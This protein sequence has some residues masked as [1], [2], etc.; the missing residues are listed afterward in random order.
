MVVCRGCLP[1]FEV[2]LVMLAREI[3]KGAKMDSSSVGVSILKVQNRNQST[4]TCFI[5]DCHYH[6]RGNDNQSAAEL[7][8]HTHRQF[9]RSTC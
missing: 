5:H 4:C 9:A 8:Q 3:T 6:R 1:D 7:A 2:T